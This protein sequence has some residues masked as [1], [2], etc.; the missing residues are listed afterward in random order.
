MRV[1]SPPGFGL[2]T[3]DLHTPGFLGPLSSGTYQLRS[4]PELPDLPVESL[5][6]F[7]LL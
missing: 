6:L 3:A 4:R 5:T 2:G 1:G 7:V